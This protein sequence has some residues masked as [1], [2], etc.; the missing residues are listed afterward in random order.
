MVPVPTVNM[1]RGD[2]VFHRG[3]PGGPQI[4]R[5]PADTSLIVAD[6]FGGEIIRDARLHRLA[7]AWAFCIPKDQNEGAGQPAGGIR[8]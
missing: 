5:L 6:A 1:D 8:S 3:L 4:A 7:K 2:Q